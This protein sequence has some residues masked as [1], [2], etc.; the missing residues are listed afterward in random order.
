MK[1]SSI[2]NIHLRPNIHQLLANEKA[3]AL[4]VQYCKD[5]FAGESIDCYKLI[6]DYKSSFN[7]IYN[8]NNN[9]RR[10]TIKLTSSKSISTLFEKEV[11]LQQQESSANNNNNNN[12]NSGNN[13]SGNSSGGDGGNNNSNATSN[14]S[15]VNNDSNVTINNNCNNSD[16]NNNI[17]TTNS[18]SLPTATTSMTSMATATTAIVI[19]NNNKKEEEE[20]Q[21]YIKDLLQKIVK[22]YIKQGSEFEINIDSQTRKIT[23]NKFEKYKELSKEEKIEIFSGVEFQILL[24]LGSDVLPR[25]ARSKLWHKFVTED[26]ETA[27]ECCSLEDLEL[28]KNLKYTKE[29]MRRT[30][31]T[32]KDIQFAD[33]VCLDYSCFEYLASSKDINVYFCLGDTFFE[34]LGIGKSN[35]AKAIG[36][37][38]FSAEVVMSCL[39]DVGALKKIYPTTVLDTN[40]N[41]EEVKAFSDVQLIAC[42]VE[43]TL[44]TSYSKYHV[45]IAS[46]FDLRTNHCSS[47]SIYFNSKYYFIVKGIY[48]TEQT[49]TTEYIYYKNGKRKIENT[50]PMVS[51]SIH[52]IT[53]ISKDKCH[54]IHF[55]SGNIGGVF[56]KIT[57]LGIFKKLLGKVS[58]KSRETLISVLN[59]FKQE[60]YINIKDGYERVRESIENFNKVYEIGE[61]CPFPKTFEE[62][63]EL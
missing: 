27:T 56:T 29:D 59:E 2:I 44:P 20:G 62:F 8:T 61:A 52:V 24:M 49:P 37:L 22:E 46:F 1:V 12:N 57:T 9:N 53:P 33:M 7:K 14:N 63:Q 15:F 19:D 36:Y 13:N 28:L 18:G 50:V 38:P 6:Q 31:M 5:N 54:Y 39:M 41:G 45:K 60:K 55:A 23:M 11:E 58:V 47:C 21:E 16:T 43:K 34:D 4:F 10:K 48:D 32:M 42:N 25:F 35:I 3:N 26:S 17:T 40:E 30:I 51:I